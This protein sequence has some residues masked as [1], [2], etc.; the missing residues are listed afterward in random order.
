MTT[1]EQATLERIRA[2]V[3]KNF[4]TIAGYAHQLSAYQTGKLD[5][6]QMA[7]WIFEEE[8]KVE[9][10]KAEGQVQS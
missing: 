7:L 9:A 3:Q 10:D 1:E 4:D 6:Y 5:A 8:T 2:R